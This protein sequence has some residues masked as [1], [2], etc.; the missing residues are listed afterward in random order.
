MSQEVLL[1]V[2]DMIP[3]ERHPKIF[4]TWE[5]L[6]VGGTIKLV[7]DHDPKPLFYEFRAER[8]GEFEW[9]AVEKG[10]E[11]WTVLIKRVAPAPLRAPEGAAERPNW[12]RDGS[13]LVDV[14][15]DLRAGREPLQKIMAAAS[16]VE[17]GEVLVV[18][19]TFEPRPLFQVLGMKGFEAWSE[20]LA[21]ED[22]KV[23]FLRKPKHEGCGCGGHGH[24]EAKQPGQ[25][26][27]LDVSQMEPPQPM[28]EI[29]Q[30]IQELGPKDILEVSHH[31]EPV[32]LY[33][34][35]EESGFDHSIEKLGEHQFRLRIWRKRDA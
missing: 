26:L 6:P 30:K 7:N 31:R 21:E 35:L 23:Y 11:R 17:P 20:R 13:K 2:R 25:L 14:R 28:I 12:A 32:P 4:N 3:R 29:L 9:N 33:P 27:T 1:D 34:Q 22:W 5:G 24:G 18:R 15:E 8:T 10:P 16:S 19:A